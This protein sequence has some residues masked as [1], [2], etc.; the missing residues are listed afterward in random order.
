MHFFSN[1][2]KNR[3]LN[4][5]KVKIMRLKL[6][7]LTSLLL[8]SNISFAA[9]TKDM[10]VSSKLENFCRISI[11]NVNFG[12]LTGVVSIVQPLVILCNKDTQMILNGYST[13]NPEGYKGGFLTMNGKTVTQLGNKDR[14]PGE[15]IRYH[16]WTELIQT[17]TDY[18]LIFK[19]DTLGK[20]FGGA[21]YSTLDY[22]LILKTKNT[23]EFN[24]PLNFKVHPDFVTQRYLFAPGNY[25]D[26]FLITVDY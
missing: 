2:R 11:N 1:M 25:F 8:I 7:L 5:L 17:G 23:T 14:I 3:I 20:K 15:G 24:L 4:K 9:V 22:R 12:E 16:A 19:N 21:D 18:S 13:N 10:K 26:S 6:G